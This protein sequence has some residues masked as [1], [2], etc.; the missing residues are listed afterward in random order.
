MKLLYRVRPYEA[1]KG[2]SDRTAALCIRRCRE[3][4]AKGSRATFRD[5]LLRIVRAF[6]AISVSNEKKPRVGLVGEILVKYHPAA[7][8]RMAEFLEAEGAE[9]VVPDSPS[10]SST[11]PSGRG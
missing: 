10:F 9:I 11:V 6:E 4:L 3:S 2:E 8:N 5:D 7:N 1:I